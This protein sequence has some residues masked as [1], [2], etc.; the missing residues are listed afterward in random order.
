[1]SLECCL[2]LWDSY[3]A[4]AGSGFDLHVYV[5]LAI[6]E[7]FQSDLLELDFPEIMAFLRHVPRNLDMDKIIHHAQCMALEQQP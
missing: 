7:H 4:Y 3:F 5:C 1:M 2:R 6:L